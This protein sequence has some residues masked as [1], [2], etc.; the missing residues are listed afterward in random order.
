[1]VK[2]T[3][4][5]APAALYFDHFDS[6]LFTYT[7]FRFQK[8]IVWKVRSLIEVLENQKSSTWKVLES[9]GISF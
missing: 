3:T 2:V 1:M 4:V 6:F 9:P 8:N 7:F 5:I